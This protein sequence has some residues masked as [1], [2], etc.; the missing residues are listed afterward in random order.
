MLDMIKQ[1][2]DE[3]II[4]QV[5]VNMFQHLE[6]AGLYQM[7]DSA[8]IVEVEY[9]KQIHQLYFLLGLLHFSHLITIRR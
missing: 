2:E 4:L 1:I 7:I 5:V 6:L 3:Y 8:R 9:F